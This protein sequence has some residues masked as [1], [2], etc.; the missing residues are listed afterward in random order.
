[1]T[2]FTVTSAAAKTVLASAPQGT[3]GWHSATF[4][5]LLARSARLE[6]L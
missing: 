5:P 4:T 6:T 1:M 3:S 2:G